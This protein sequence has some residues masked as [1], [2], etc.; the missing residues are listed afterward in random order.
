MLVIMISLI[1]M[2]MQMQ[3][4]VKEMEEPLATEYKK[5]MDEKNQQN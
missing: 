5:S 3:A 2:L 1:N 4:M